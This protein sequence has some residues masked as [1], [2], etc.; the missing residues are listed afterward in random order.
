M[1][2]HTRL[3]GLEGGS[4]GHRLRTARNICTAWI[5]KLCGM[6]SLSRPILLKWI[7][8]VA[9]AASF[10]PHPAWAHVK[11]FEPYDVSSAPTPLSGVLTGHFL[12][13]CAGFTLLVVGSFLF[14]RLVATKLPAIAAPGRHEDLEE[15]VL[16]PE[17]A[18]SSWRCSQL[19]GPFLRRNYTLLPTGR[20]GS[21][22]A[23]PSA[24]SRHV[25]AC[26]EALAFSRSMATALHSTEFFHLSDY[27][28][29]LG[30]AVY[31][32]L[33]S[34]T[35]GRLR[36][37]RMLVLYVS[38]CVSLMWGAVEK[39]AYPQWT[40]PLLAERPYLTFGLLPADFMVVAGFV[41]FAF[42]FYILTGHGLLRLAIL[43]LGTIFAAAIIDFGKIDAIGHMPILI[44]FIA[45]FLHGPTPTA[46]LASRQFR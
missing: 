19:A 37:Q 36:S 32:G 45:M 9:A 1:R 16:Q 41:E 26:L 20:P 18:L 2:R 25:P 7:S 22:S 15:R 4:E 17:P 14:D 29:F 24:C 34:F 30:L 35:N 5:S 12:L 33:T 11:W 27:P 38:I 13:V 23:L 46:S 31:L 43:G 28:M 39:W 6:V 8:A 40:L 44:A 21:S 42:A 3:I 10:L